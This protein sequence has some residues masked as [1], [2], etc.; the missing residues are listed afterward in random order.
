MKVKR[1]EFQILISIQHA[2]IIRMAEEAFLPE[3]TEI[4][5]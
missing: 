5:R 4:V 1:Y 2:M 3:K